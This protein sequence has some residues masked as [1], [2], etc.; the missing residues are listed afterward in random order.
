M[1]VLYL[2]KC[3][4][5]VR[6]VTTEDLRGRNLTRKQRRTYWLEFTKKNSRVNKEL[7]VN[8]DMYKTLI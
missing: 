1:T 5:N 6:L 7:P 2:G 3:R 8:A 4:S